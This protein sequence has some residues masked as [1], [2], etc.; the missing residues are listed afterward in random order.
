MEPAQGLNPNRRSISGLELEILVTLSSFL[1]ISVS[2]D[3]SFLIPFILSCLRLTQRGIFGLRVSDLYY[4]VSFAS[5]VITV[6][7]A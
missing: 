2:A 1:F 3:S 5:S 4:P 6:A 7:A